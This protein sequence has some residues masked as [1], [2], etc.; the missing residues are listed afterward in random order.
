MVLK[1]LDRVGTIAMEADTVLFLEEM[2][3]ISVIKLNIKKLDG[4]T[5]EIGYAYLKHIFVGFKVEDC[6]P[7]ETNL[8]DWNEELRKERQKE[9]S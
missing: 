3:Q 6:L 2:S 7:N 4:C 5:G 9:S 1:D 8:I